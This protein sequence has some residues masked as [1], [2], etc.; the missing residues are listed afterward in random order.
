MCD[1][2]SRPGSVFAVWLTAVRPF[3]YSASVVAVALGLGLARYLGHP[4]QW[5]PFVLTLVGVVCFHT[6]ANLLNDCY[7]HRRGT[8]REVLPTSGA[9]VRGWLTERQVFRG[10][11]VCLAIGAACGFVLVCHAGWVVLLLGAI[12][13]VMAL[14]YTTP[15]FCFK[16]AGLGDLAIFCAFGVLPVFGTYWVQSRTFSWAPIL[17]SLPLVLYTVG[18]LHANN[19]RDLAGDREK[20]CRTIAGLLGNR[21]SAWYYRILVL[22]PFILVGMYMLAG[23]FPATGFR[24]PL[25]VALVYLVLPAAARLAKL[26]RWRD[27]GA[28]ALLD[29]RTAQLQT[30]FGSLLTVGFFVAVYV[31]W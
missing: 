25:S 27:A 19:W 14:G 4:V 24:P 29:A 17:W 3:A 1:E 21:G 12:G 10:A 7:D 30:I 16:Y 9:V 8:D 23:C 22:G 13:S 28:P 2:E 6:A 18:I 26:D 20:G 11:V 31:P 15:R 5:W